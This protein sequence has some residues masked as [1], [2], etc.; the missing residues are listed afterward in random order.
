MGTSIL[1]RL[2][3]QDRALFAR[4]TLER[5]TTGRRVWVACTHLGGVWCIVALTA[6]PLFAVGALHTVAVHAA[7]GLAVSHAIVQ[8]L[9]RN[10]LRARPADGAESLVAIPDE[11]SFPSGHAAAAMAVA[12][13]YAAAYPAMALPL[14]GVAA[15]VGFSRVCLGVHYPGDVLVGQA[16]AVMTDIVVLS[17]S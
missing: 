15:A 4:W 1:A 10:V 12:V 6:V 8:I 3:A 14:L 11:F 2:D 5:S 16:I 17:V 13:V 9:K 7:V